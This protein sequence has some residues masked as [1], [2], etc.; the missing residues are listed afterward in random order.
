MKERNEV[1]GMNRVERSGVERVNEVNGMKRSEWS[2]Q[3]G[4]IW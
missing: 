4:T 1:N 3:S 2:E